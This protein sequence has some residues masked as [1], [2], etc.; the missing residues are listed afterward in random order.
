MIVFIYKV[1]LKCSCDT[2][3]ELPKFI[4][5]LMHVNAILNVNNYIVWHWNK[6]IY[7]YICSYKKKPPEQKALSLTNN[8]ESYFYAIVKNYCNA[9]DT[10]PWLLSLSISIAMMYWRKRHGHIFHKDLMYQ[11]YQMSHHFCKLITP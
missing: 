6:L 3:I 7:I 10:D 4:T 5:V 9:S 2:V 11:I 1:W 8:Q